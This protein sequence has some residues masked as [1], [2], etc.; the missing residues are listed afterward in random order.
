MWGCMVGQVFFAGDA[1]L[2]CHCQG[3]FA[4]C[5]FSEEN[6]SCLELVVTGCIYPL[7]PSGYRDSSG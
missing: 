1:F 7:L 4:E 2:H 6:A 5:L 3:L